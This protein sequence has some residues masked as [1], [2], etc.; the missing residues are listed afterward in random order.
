MH[1]AIAIT[2]LFAAAT[3]GFGAE[4]NL[5]GYFRT[6]QQRGGL[7]GAIVGY[8]FGGWFMFAAVWRV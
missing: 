1:T 2:L 7:A 8:L 6:S 4:R 5:K 3:S